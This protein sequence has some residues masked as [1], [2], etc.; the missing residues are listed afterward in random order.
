MDIH[1][2]Q[3]SYWLPFS[4]MGMGIACMYVYALCMCLVPTVF[5]R[6]HQLPW[7]QGYSCEPLCGCQ[8][9]NH[10]L[11]QKQVLLTTEPPLP[12]SPVSVH[13]LQEFSMCSGYLATIKRV[14]WRFSILSIVFLA[15]LYH[16]L[17]RES[18]RQ[19]AGLFDQWIEFSCWGG[20]C[21]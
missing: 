7:C 2:T 3:L 16:P 20:L 8:E 1:H 11:L 5:K 6:G 4:F 17:M 19:T 13:K 10:S 18:S 14:T 9:L 15:P 12:P 21:K